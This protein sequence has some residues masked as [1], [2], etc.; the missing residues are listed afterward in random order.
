MLIMLTPNQVPQLW[1]QIKFAL[2]KSNDL[3]K[4]KNKYFNKVLHGLLSGNAQCFIRL[5]DQRELEL[6]TITHIS[7]D[8]RTNYNVLSVEALYSF[9]VTTDSQW[10]DIVSEMKKLAENLGCKKILAYTSNPR[11][12][13]ITMSTGFKEAFRCFEYRLE[14]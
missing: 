5:N 1:E 12:F 6:I 7:S 9:K 3:G 11:V 4:D 10:E 2:D 8:I 13:E 14:A